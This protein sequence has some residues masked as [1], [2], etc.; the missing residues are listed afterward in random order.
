MA[1]GDRVKADQYLQKALTIEEKLAP[2]SVNLA[3][4]LGN[5][6]LL[7][8]E[9][10]NLPKADFY[11]SG[12]LALSERLAPG[13]S[14][15]AM[16]L[17]QKGLIARQEG[18]LDLAEL[19][20]SQSV[21][22]LDGLSHRLGGSE[23]TRASFRAEREEYYQEYMDI[24]LEL[25]RPEE[26]FHVLERG[27][28]RSLLAMLA[29][30]DLVFG[31]ELPAEI[32]QARKL[33]AS[34]YDRTF[35][36]LSKLKSTK[37]SAQIEDL[38]GRLRDLNTEREE[39]TERIRRS[40]PRLANLQYPQPLDFAATRQLLD[41]G[42]ALL[43][44]SVS[45]E[46]IVLFVVRP[47]QEAPGLSVFTIPVEEKK[48]RAQIEGFRRLTLERRSTIDN[49]FVSQA[50]SL[51]DLLLKPAES[52][53]ASSER[54]L[55]V[56]DGTL[57]G[58]PFAAL[59]RRRN[60]YLVEWKPIHTVVSAT[61]YAELK[62]ERRTAP[63]PIDLV[64]FGD[65]RYPSNTK[66]QPERNADAELVAATERGLT[67]SP[68]LFSRAEVDSITALYPGRSRK[69][70]G[71]EATEERA[72][73][74][75][76]NVRYV[77]FAV[78]GILDDRFPLNSALALTIPDKPSEGQDNGLLQ[79]WEIFERV[80]LDADLVT[81]SACNTGMGQEMNGEGLI[82]LT[83]AFQYAGAHSIL[84]SLWA[85]DD[86]RTMQ[87]MKQV[88]IGLRAG[89][90][91]DEALREAQLSLLRSQPSSAPYYWAAFSLIGDWR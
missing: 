47:M 21:D 17:R 85:V 40:S 44:Y 13:T 75:G 79:A 67:L 70:E 74:I 24:L 10:G 12:T 3:L 68:L 76:M 36:Q 56:P 88:Y 20:L 53:F 49:A 19:Y 42:T 1:N 7:A 28:A 77:H 29:E 60:Q 9:S 35:A 26:A 72:K 64:A 4:T 6:G 31:A 73:S 45:K 46:R 61:V 41:A 11:F 8:I 62:K 66:N 2:V 84:A 18:K 27:R 80:R 39:I 54:L 38:Q 78:H 89:K 22:A 23:E 59:L 91:K 34:S 33:N 81:L 82:G 52:A 58:L 57:N 69:Y 51:Y 63:K 5:L 83:R 55:V 48:L 37:D 32:E 25:K 15:Y 90:T 71:A 87:L 50:R 65:P 14:Y 30:R 16:V 43:S 86:M